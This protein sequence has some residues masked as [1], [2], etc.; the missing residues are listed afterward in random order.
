MMDDIKKLGAASPKLK[1]D[2]IF[3]FYFKIS[4]Y[5]FSQNFKLLSRSFIDSGI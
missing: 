5:E 2:Y 4:F 1:L 3:I